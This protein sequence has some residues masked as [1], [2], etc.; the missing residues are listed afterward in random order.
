MEGLF[1]YS[2]L[3]T[4]VK[5]MQSNML[6]LKDY[7]QMAHMKEVKDVALYLK[8]CPAYSQTL[9]D[10]NES[11]IHRGDIEKKI[12]YS[13]YKD[14][15]KIYRF[16]NGKDRNFLNAYFIYFE[17]EILKM[18]LRTV[19][20]SRQI[21]YDLKDFEKFFNEHSAINVKKLSKAKNL[22]EFIETLKDTSYYDM[23]SVIHNVPKQT[24]FDAELQ[25]DLYYFNYT[26][27]VKNKYLDGQNNKAV[28]ETFGAR[29]DLLNIL[30]IY[31]A[32]INYK[33]DKDIIYTYIIPIYY[34]LKKNQIRQ[35]I[36]ARNFEEFYDVVKN[37]YYSNSLKSFENGEAEKAYF[38]F[39]S[40]E[41][42][43][44]MA[45]NPMSLAPIRYFMFYKKIEIANITKL[46]EGVRYSLN[47]DEIIKHLNTVM[48]VK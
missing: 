7:E 38:S 5:A 22:N 44:A 36:E 29:I 12:M 32:K 35:M 3:V 10:I 30:W 45:Q 1:K 40:K 48:V 43:K 23:L 33:I 37:T 28:T 39:V 2:G 19:F 34:K 8:Q 21:D 26:W 18:L 41:H 31:R 16:T 24:L 6:T 15:E 46:I 25:L 47:P 17:I 20:D 11:D 13:M 9:S 42:K 14:Y 4:K 27:K